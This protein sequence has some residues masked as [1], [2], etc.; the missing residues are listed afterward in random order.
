VIAAFAARRR[1]P[2]WPLEPVLTAT[3]AAAAA[4][5][6]ARSSGVPDHP[7]D[8]LPWRRWAVMS[9]TAPRRRVEVGDDEQSG[10]GAAHHRDV[11]GR[12]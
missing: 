6:L 1:T 3:T 9:P 5:T 11:L 8:G 4:V 12:G 2:L 7:V 10:V